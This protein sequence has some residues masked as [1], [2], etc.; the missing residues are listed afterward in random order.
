MHAIQ[1]LGNI[2]VKLGRRE[3]KPAN[4]TVIPCLSQVHSS[5]FFQKASSAYRLSCSLVYAATLSAR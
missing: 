2:V 3:T 4:Q 5:A 1:T